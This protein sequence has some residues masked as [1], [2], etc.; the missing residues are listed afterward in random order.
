MKFEKIVTKDGSY[1]FYN[2]EVGD[3]YKATN[4]ALTESVK[5]H[6]TGLRFEEC[7][8][9]EIVIID[10]C[11]GAGY[12]SLAAIGYIR[13]YHPDKK[14]KIY[15]L[16]NDKEIMDMA[17]HVD[18]NDVTEDLGIDVS[19]YIMIQNFITGFIKEGKTEHEEDG[20]KFIMCF[21]DAKEEILK[22]DADS[23][24]CIFDPFSPSKVPDMW[25]VEF[26]KNVYDKLIHG[27][28]LSTYSCARF[29]KDNFEAAGFR[30]TKGPTIGR[31]SPSTVAVKD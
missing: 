12:N 30:L 24:F 17:N 11:A 16:E 23:E 22:I 15:Y 26:M 20:V 19:Y 25:T 27:A 28:R 7:T 21:G 6:A 10:L 18:F 1:T 31:R 13:K 2:D 14:I 3:H 8:S 4:G 5:K 29:I 9:D